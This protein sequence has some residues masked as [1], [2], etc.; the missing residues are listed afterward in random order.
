[1]Q[2][3][4]EY[5]VGAI[6][7]GRSHNSARKASIS[8]LLFLSTTSWPSSRWH[9]DARGALDFAKEASLNGV[10][11]GVIEASRRGTWTINA[12]HSI[13]RCNTI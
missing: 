9:L 6:R 1:M 13:G 11:R 10:C 12:V 4:L 8:Y 5:N 7:L 2:I 3:E